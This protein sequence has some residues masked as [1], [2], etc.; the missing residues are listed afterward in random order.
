VADLFERLVEH[1]PRDDF[2]T[3]ESG[4]GGAADHDKDKAKRDFGA[5]RYI[6][7]EVEHGE[8][9]MTNDE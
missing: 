2:G 8:L 7:E 6:A 4:N 9:R 3:Q 1:C 5:K